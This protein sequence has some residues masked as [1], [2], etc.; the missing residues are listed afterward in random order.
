MNDEAETKQTKDDGVAAT[1]AFSDL[2]FAGAFSSEYDE[3]LS[4]E[5]AAAIALALRE[6][7][8][9]EEAAVMQQRRAVEDE[10]KSLELAW[11]IQTREARRST[12]STVP[13]TSASISERATSHSPSP[14]R[15]NPSN[16]RH[17]SNQHKLIL[18]CCFLAIAGIMFGAGYKLGGAQYY[19]KLVD[20][21]GGQS[22]MLL[23]RVNSLLDM[24][25]N[26]TLLQPVSNKNNLTVAAYYYPWYGRWGNFHGGKFLRY[27][28]QCSCFVSAVAQILI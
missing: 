23:P 12:S 8:Q 20:K 10:Q 18:V 28:C 1:E 11:K 22:S 15:A 5:D 13:T 16:T 2:Q 7:R 24:C 19:D 17:L 9:D 14:Q 21:N 6:A 27:V 4:E 25:R 3:G 26:G